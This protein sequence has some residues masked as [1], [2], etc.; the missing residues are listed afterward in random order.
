MS[1]LLP[2]PLIPA[3]RC[4][5]LRVRSDRSPDPAAPRGA[6]DRGRPR[7][8]GGP[9][10]R[11][12]PRHRTRAPGRPPAQRPA[13]LRRRPS[14]PDPRGPT[15]R[16]DRTALARL[17]AGEPVSREPGSPTLP[18]APHL[19][20]GPAPAWGL[21]DDGPTAP[22]VVA[23]DDGGDEASWLTALAVT[24][25][26]YDPETLAAHRHRPRHLHRPDRPHARRAEARPRDG[27]RAHGAALRR[28]GLPTSTV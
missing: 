12:P 2:D 18:S 16:W 11:A 1:T 28:R 27:P 8:G 26:R 13:A 4:H 9:A 5:A 24:L 6:L 20:R 21:G 14:R 7:A 19:G 3:A 22:H 17:A 25:R 23:L 10:R 15:G